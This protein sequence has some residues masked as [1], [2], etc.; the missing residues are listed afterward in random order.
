MIS[1]EYPYLSASPDLKVACECCGDGLVEIKC[2]YTIRDKKPT[3]EML[4]QIGT[5]QDTYKL[6]VNTDHYFQIQGQLGVTGLIFC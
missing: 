5:D 3:P 1:H 6:K 4:P 2:P